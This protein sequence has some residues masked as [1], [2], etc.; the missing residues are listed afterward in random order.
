MNII[1]P[2]DSMSKQQSNDPKELLMETTN[3]L[4]TLEAVEEI[5]RIQLVQLGNDLRTAQVVESLIGKWSAE[6]HEH[7]V[8]LSSPSLS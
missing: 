7:I 4:N 8:S 1:V 6:G 3:S 2:L 5:I